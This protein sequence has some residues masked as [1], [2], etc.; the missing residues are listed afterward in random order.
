MANK[1]LILKSEID[2]ST[3]AVL[4]L[5]CTAQEITSHINRNLGAVGL[6]QEQ[7]QV[8]HVLDESPESFLTVNQIKSLFVTDNPNISRM[9]NKLVEK[10]LIVK[11]RDQKDQ[12]IVYVRITEEGRKMHLKADK[13]FIE[14]MPGLTEKDAQNLLKIIKKL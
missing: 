11:N 3:K 2:D 1:D 4:V 5:L 6:S 14:A 8:L 9:L 12:R 7:L 10:G 13:I